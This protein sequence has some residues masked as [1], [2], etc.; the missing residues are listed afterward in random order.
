MTAVTLAPANVRTHRV[1]DLPAPAAS[2]T[3]SPIKIG[4]ST[5]HLR[6]L[7]LPW[8]L[9][10]IEV[11]RLDDMEFAQRSLEMAQVLYRDGDPFKYLFAVRSGSLKSSLLS[12][13]GREQI[14]GFHIAGDLV[15]MD[16]VARGLYASCAT[17]LEDTQVCAIPYAGLSDGAGTTV[18]MQ[19][20]ISRLMSREI[21]RDHSVMM[22][23]ASM[24]AEGRL[25]A[26]LLNLSQR[27]AARGYSR[28]EFHL[29]M[30][31]ADIGSYLGM[32]IETVSRTF[33]ILQKQRLLEVDKRLVRITDLE[34]LQRL[35]EASTA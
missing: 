10:P 34:G 24:N 22:L 28:R 17:A 13:D 16:G 1:T 15:G 3:V 21:V 4:C 25:A 29:R 8:G 23:L 6:G 26:F 33:S 31:R 30:S 20:M 32:K 35:F 9:S 14:S 12:L 19:R 27:Y 5:C 11:K 2:S 18:G 7:C